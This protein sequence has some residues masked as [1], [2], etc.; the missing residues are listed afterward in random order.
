VSAPLRFEKP[1]ILA[2]IQGAAAKPPRHVAIE[3]SAG[4]GKTYTI[5]HAVV[6]FVLRGVKLENL[7]VVTFTE[8]ATHELRER[9]RAKLA[10]ILRWGG[11]PARQPEHF[12]EIDAVARER[13]E[14]A[15]T[16]FDQASIFTIHGFCQ[17][18]LTENAFLARRLFD[19]ELTDSRTAF[20]VAWRHVLRRELATDPALREDLGAWLESSTV[21]KLEELLHGVHKERA[22]VRPRLDREAFAAALATL[23]TK[24]AFDA[25]RAQLEA[26][27]IHGGTKKALLLRVDALAAFFAAPERPLSLVRLHASEA[28]SSPLRFIMERR[29]KIEPVQAARPFLAR[30][31]VLDGLFV[32]VEAAAAQVFL[33]VVERQLARSKEELGQYDFDDMLVLV[34]RALASGPESALLKERLRQRYHHALIDEFQDTDEVQWNVFRELFVASPGEHG[35]WVIGDPKQAIYAFRGADVFA[36]L[37]ARDA[38]TRGGATLVPLVQNFRSTGRLIEAY[39]RIF[40]Q[41]ARPPFFR[42]RIRY[43]APVEC[44]RPELEATDARG[45]PVAPVHVFHVESPRE[46]LRVDDV[47]R[48]VGTRIA[49]EI[50]RILAGE[51]RF[52][53][54]DQPL[55][56]NDIFILTRSGWEGPDVARYLRAEGIPFAFYK[57]DGLFQTAEAGDL[58]SVLEAVLEPES[59][60]KRFR[61]WTT[62]FFGVSLEALARSG[63]PPGDHALWRRLH[64]WRAL[65]EKRRYEELFASLVEDTG[66]VRRELFFAASERQLTNYLHILELLLEAVTRSRLELREL[67]AL[68]GTWIDESGS[69]EGEDG[70]VQR[71]ESDARAVQIMTMHKSK[72]LEAAVVFLYGGYSDPKARELQVYHE[73]REERPRADDAEEPGPRVTVYHDAQGKRVVHVGQPTPEIEALVASEQADEARRLLYV[74]ITRAKARLYLVSFG[75]HTITE[76]NGETRLEWDFPRLG[77]CYVHLADRLDALL[78]AGPTDGLFHVEKVVA[79]ERRPPRPLA[80]A[81]SAATWTPPPELVTLPRASALERECRSLLGARAHAPLVVTSYTRLKSG[82]AGG[83]IVADEFRGEPAPATT[84]AEGPRPGVRTGIFFHEV[85]ETLPFESF[86]GRPI[87]AWRERED[88]K[89]VFARTMARHGIEAAH[90]AAC[91]RLVFRSLSAPVPGVGAGLGSVRGGLKELE[92]VY[93]I[94]ERAHLALPPGER[95]TVERGYVRGFIDFVFRHQGLAYVVDWKTDVL[96]DY[97]EDGM[98][99]SVDESYRLQ[100]ELYTLALVKML[101]VTSAGDHEARVGGVLY[102]FLRGMSPEKPGGVFF[103]RPSFEDT[104]RFTEKLIARDFR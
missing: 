87:D 33:P 48:L 101:G 102:C 73:A 51:L 55:A 81:A 6:D 82:A 20:G 18:V 78:N 35:L 90:R 47:R 2:R 24:G 19:Q 50:K 103:E 3:A 21:E 41:R 79:E 14:R 11:R 23:A 37:G 91:E 43:D 52:N 57:Q 46:P 92:F 9:I 32:S 42:D 80:A 25:F 84:V 68:L 13:L 12:W 38:L 85:I 63:D 88:V 54:T 45:R 5:E 8:K 1:G 94:P 30:L 26:S 95:L 97:G 7:L 4:T 49:R 17:R 77:G 31:A 83:E 39:N 61:A 15:L 71:L 59:R 58:L 74:A 53:G 62:P 69:P 70:N 67:V 16:G 104:Q 72:G 40:D 22:E 66:L 60:P 28:L 65:A 75:T 100:L 99:A 27:R 36:Y 86:D 29:D 56:A 34:E 10:E 96:D 76:E 64:A 44:G 89:R 93:P 98:R